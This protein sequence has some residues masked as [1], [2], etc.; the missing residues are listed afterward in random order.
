M[1]FGELRGYYYKH[2]KGLVLGIKYGMF[3]V[4]SMLVSS[5]LLDVIALKLVKIF[6]SVNIQSNSR[7]IDA[8]AYSAS[9]RFKV[10]TYSL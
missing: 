4:N 8:Q 3:L 7:T 5:P 9:M 6:T 2:T 10:S 1:K